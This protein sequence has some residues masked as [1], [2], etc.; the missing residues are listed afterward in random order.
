[1]I[2]I[3]ATV[4]LGW[5]TIAVAVAVAIGRIIRERDTHAR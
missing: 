2:A 4:A 1:M 3:L 5:V